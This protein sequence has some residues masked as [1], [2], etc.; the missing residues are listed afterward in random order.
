MADEEAR[1]T[2]RETLVE[3][4][5]QHSEPEAPA[6]PAG[7]LINQ[8]TDHPGYLTP[9]ESAQ[10]KAIRDQK[11][12]RTAG[13][14]RA[15]DG[16]LLPGKAQRDSAAQVQKPVESVLSS[17]PAAQPAP[18]AAEPALPAIPRPSSWKKEMWPVWDKLTTGQQLTPQEARQVA[19]YNAQRET[20]F[21]TG[22]STYKQI[23]DTA[24]PVMDA[25]APFQADLDKHGIQAPDMVYRLMSAH[26]TL[27]LGGPQQKLQLFAKLANDYGI[28]IQALYDEGV[29][30]Q[31]FA[32][33]PPQAQQPAQQSMPDIN[34]L[35]NQALEQRE[36][37]QTVASM[38]SNKE[39]YPFFSYVRPTMAQLL[40]SGEATDLEDA[41][42]KAL[43][44]PEH[45]LLTTVQQQQQAQAAEQQRVAAAKATAQV[46]RANTVSPRSA[47]P[48]AAAPS[49]GNKGVR[50]A[51]RE[52][53]SQHAGN[54][55][56]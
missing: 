12:G 22:V 41:Y 33:A 42:Q 36:V 38:A 48:A 32:S 11:P 56:V 53:I 4:I 44:D 20:Q 10:E 47:T 6:A 23:A 55:R 46:A 8:D 49:G 28:P 21:A 7:D 30:N 16:K 29:R 31:F 43:N 27:A 39:K 50:D 17:A 3:S 19:E 15:P 40:E 52:A 14:A 2:L 45:E 25:I 18:A 24:K 5:A 54:A 9:P 13:R 26:K 35:V 1:A 34:A 37:K 51:L